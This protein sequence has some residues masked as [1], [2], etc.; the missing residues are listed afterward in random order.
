MSL[1]A[2]QRDQLIVFEQQTTAENDLGEAVGTWAELTRA[3][4][5]MRWGSG[6]ER[7]QMVQTQAEQAAI[8]TVAAVAEYLAV[9]VGMRIRRGT[10]EVWNIDAIAA[11]TRGEIAFTCTRVAQP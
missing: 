9:T 11:V 7:L 8:F 2:G 4:A 1:H 6:S 10:A 3:W 5:M